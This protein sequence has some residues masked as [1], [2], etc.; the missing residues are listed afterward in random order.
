[1]TISLNS[2]YNLTLPFYF[3]LVGIILFSFSLYAYSI[4]SILFFAMITP[5]GG[6]S[7]IVGWISIIYSIIKFKE[8]V[9]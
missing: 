9:S 1:L 2:K 3:I 8:I 5:F 7:L 4:T 6:V